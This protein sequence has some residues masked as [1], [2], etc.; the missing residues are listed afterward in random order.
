MKYLTSPT[1]ATFHTKEHTVKQIAKQT[2]KAASCALLG[3]SLMLVTAPSFAI[4]GMNGED[5]YKTLC[6]S[7]HG[8]KGHGDGIAGKALSEQPSNIYDG[9]TSW[10]E[11]ESELIDTVLNG[12]EGMPAWNAVLTEQ[13]VKQIFA[14]IRDVNES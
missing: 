11:T 2:A 6:Q 12:N 3:A 8:E 10:F 4:E 14:Y 1:K 7:C 5:T 9:L 13:E